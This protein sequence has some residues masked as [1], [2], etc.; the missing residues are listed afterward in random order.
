[1]A[2]QVTTTSKD[3]P[4]L[5]RCLRVGRR[6][7]VPGRPLKRQRTKVHT[8]FDDDGSP[9]TS[10]TKAST[11]SAATSTAATATDQ[12]PNQDKQ[13]HMTTRL[14]VGGLELPMELVSAVQLQVQLPRTPHA[15]SGSAGTVSRRIPPTNMH[16][17]TAIRSWSAVQVHT[18]LLHVF[19]H[20]YSIMYS[21]NTKHRWL[22]GMGGIKTPT[23]TS[24]TFQVHSTLLLATTSR[25]PASPHFPP[26][27]LLCRPFSVPGYRR[28]NGDFSKD[29]HAAFRRQL[30]RFRRHKWALYP[31]WG[32][33][34][35][36]LDHRT[37]RLLGEV[38]AN[39]AVDV[40]P[41]AL[42]LCAGAQC[43]SHYA[44]CVVGGR[45]RPSSFE[46]MPIQR[47][48]TATDG[49]AGAGAAAG[50][51]QQQHQSPSIMKMLKGS[52]RVRSVSCR[53]G[54]ACGQAAADTPL[55]RPHPHTECSASRGLC[56]GVCL[57][58]GHNLGDTGGAKALCPH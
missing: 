34:S 29:E 43:E 20:K 50:A 24:T 44:K 25:H 54:R 56:A 38:L 2:Q 28:H 1:M 7:P 48:A 57:R 19:V 21:P 5:Q 17:R 22:P 42:Q 6:F 13:A 53:C 18:S 14:Q 3:K 11:A 41:V 46:P 33:F 27:P 58:G 8:F 36:A 26:I 32:V 40:T 31:H 45:L 51:E 55:A 10:A 15:E 49:G 23:S 30:V 52:S 4:F 37:G 35:L 16:T 12:Q 47:C 9:A 39:S